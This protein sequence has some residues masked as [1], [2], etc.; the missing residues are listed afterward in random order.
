MRNFSK[1]IVLWYQENKRDLPW[2]HTKNPYFIWLSEIILQQ[3]RVEQGLV[4][5]NKFVSKFPNISLLARA[6]TQDVLKLWQ[7]L[8][9]YSRATNLHETA[10]TVFFHHK[11]RFPATYEELKKL[12]GV[13]EY[14]AAAIASFAFGLP[15]PVVDAN[16]IRVLSRIFGVT[17]NAKSAANMLQIKKLAM[18]LID[19]KDPATYNQAIMEFGALQCTKKPD[20]G[21]CIFASCCFAY[22]KGIVLEIPGKETKK[23]LRVRYFYFLLIGDKQSVWIQKRETKDIWQHLYQ[24]P[25]IESS[26]K[27]SLAWIGREAKKLL[28]RRVQLKEVTPYIDHQL[29]HQ[30][31][32]AQCLLVC[33]KITKN[34]KTRLS[35]YYIEVERKKIQH[36]PVPRLIEKILPDV[37]GL[38]C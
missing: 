11:G 38:T 35:D 21:I 36:Y 30:L 16:V 34:D 4:Y 29:S 27:A 2:R 37:V 3:T 22:K 20:C 19:K 18:Q 6:K 10:K 25:L 5:Y 7:G 23:I 26:Q 1:N 12:K 14:T 28:G 13:G 32:K 24:F 17:G 33:E 9:Y 8:G 31:I 15:Y